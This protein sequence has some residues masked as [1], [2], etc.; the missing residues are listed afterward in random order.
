MEV[1]GRALYCSQCGAQLREGAIFCSKCGTRIVVPAASTPT[2]ES[3]QQADPEK[4]NDETRRH[5]G[6]A[7][8]MIQF[9]RTTLRAVPTFVLA[10]IA[11][12]AAAGTAYALY[13]VAV[14]VI[15]PAIEQVASSEGTE[16]G[17][18]NKFAKYEG[19]WKG[20]FKE[21][22]VGTNT[23]Q[24][25]GARQREF[26]LVITSIDPHDL[27]IKGTYS[28]LVHHHARLESAASGGT[29]GD[30]MVENRPF[31]GKLDKGHPIITGGW[32]SE[33]SDFY[34]IGLDVEEPK[35]SDGQ[36]IMS[37]GL[38]EEAGA[39][40]GLASLTT[41]PKFIEPGGG[42]GSYENDTT[43]TD[44]YTLQKIS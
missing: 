44:I 19:V 11:F 32:L 35:D 13:R 33:P 37:F 40:K 34:S 42:F 29:D 23:E 2:T 30:E 41:R 18:M 28:G 27:S 6:L 10:I 22:T 21:Q 17:V 16:P 38:G 24:C 36:V 5:R 3:A 26:T 31:T 39:D 15:I 7:A 14:D 25:Y 8:T 1:G 9:R 43:F 4:T 12:L 20:T